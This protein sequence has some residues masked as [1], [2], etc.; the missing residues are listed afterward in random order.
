MTESAD[1][2]RALTLTLSQPFVESLDEQ[3]LKDYVAALV[4]ASVRAEE[5]DEFDVAASTVPQ[6]TFDYLASLE[7]VR[8]AEN[9]CLI[10]PAGTG[11]SHLLLALGSALQI[12]AGLC[13]ITGVGRPLAA[14]ALAA[15]TI[16]ATVT[17]L[18]FWHFEGPP[19]ESMRSGFIVNFAVLG[20]LLLA[21]GQ[22]L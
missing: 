2:A 1:R 12:V 15:F 7:W 19:R 21:F 3:T 10:G 8:A 14:L 4:A 11:K 18:D 13:V 17:L 22:S 20:G 16:A 6:P 9:V 5:E